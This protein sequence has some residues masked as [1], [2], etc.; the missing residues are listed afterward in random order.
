VTINVIEISESLEK[1]LI[2]FSKVDKQAEKVLNIMQPYFNK[3]KEPCFTHL[4][5][6]PCGYDFHEGSLRNLGN[7]ENLYAKFSLLA[8]G[9]SLENLRKDFDSL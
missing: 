2:K 7:L 4:I 1:E 5:R 6:V 3:V 8:K 9:H